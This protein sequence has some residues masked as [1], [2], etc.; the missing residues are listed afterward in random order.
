VTAAASA[1]V[2]D[3]YEHWARGAQGT[4]EALL[5]ATK[6]G[7]EAQKCMVVDR[8]HYK[9]N[10]DRQQGSVIVRAPTKSG[11]MVANS[12]RARVARTVV[13]NETAAQ[14]AYL[15]AAVYAEA[16]LSVAATAG[17]HYPSLVRWWPKRCRAAKANEP[18]ESFDAAPHLRILKR[19]RPL[20]AHSVG[21][22]CQVR[23]RAVRV[24]VTRAEPLGSGVAHQ[25]DHQTIRPSDH[26]GCSALLEGHQG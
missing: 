13:S 12:Q 14:R 3:I 1:A 25:T 5:G 7:Y 23:A 2:V 22:A 10:N 26:Q 11:E 16:L 8:P 19:L 18:N 21:R 4:S 17:Q 9:L 24:R 6:Q 20:Q 15:L